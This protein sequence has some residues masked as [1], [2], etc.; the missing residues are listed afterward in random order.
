[1]SGLEG[2]ETG[3]EA[4]VLV[5]QPVRGVSPQVTSSDSEEATNKSEVVVEGRGSSGVTY[6]ETLGAEVGTGCVLWRVFV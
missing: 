6:S 2:K 3:E 5:P 4:S 1:M